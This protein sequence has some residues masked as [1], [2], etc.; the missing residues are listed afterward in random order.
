MVCFVQLTCRCRSTMCTP[1]ESLLSL[2][3]LPSSTNPGSS[4][5]ARGTTFQVQYGTVVQ[6]L[7]IILKKMLHKCTSI[8]SICSAQTYKMKFFFVHF[9]A[10]IGNSFR[11]DS[12]SG[13]CH[14]TLAESTR[15]EKFY[16]YYL[17]NLCQN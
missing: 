12:A 8:N 17:I 14:S 9:L 7:A 3:K 6:D 11:V 10:L 13:E 5:L 2:L 16:C 1:R 4:S 15:G